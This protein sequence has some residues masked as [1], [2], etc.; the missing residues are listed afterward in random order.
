MKSE[1]TL[2][3]LQNLIK[4]YDIRGIAPEYLDENTLYLIGQGFMIA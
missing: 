3:R 1:I 4:A 2:E